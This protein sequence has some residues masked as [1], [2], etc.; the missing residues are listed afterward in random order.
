MELYEI[1]LNVDKASEHLYHMDAICD[2]LYPFFF[3]LLQN[4]EWKDILY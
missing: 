3:F 4:T 2:Y 1:L